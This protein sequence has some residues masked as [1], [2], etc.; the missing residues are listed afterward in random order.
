MEPISTV[1]TGI[2]L[3]QKSVDFV[4]SNI[5][6]INDIKEITGLIDKALD[7][8][9]QFQKERFSKKGIIGQ[10][11]DAAGSVIDAKLAQEQL[12]ELKKLVNQRFGSSTWQEIISDRNRRLQEEK[13]AIAEA[14][15]IARKKQEKI[16]TILKTIGISVLGILFLSAG[17]LMLFITEVF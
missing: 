15:R 3:L 13:D 7:G 12:Y 1:L 16:L 10:T 9:Q 2:A 6:T 14:K 8:E 17:I 5:N 4:K 11:K